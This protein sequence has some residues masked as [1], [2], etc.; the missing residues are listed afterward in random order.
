MRMLTYDPD[1]RISAAEAYKHKW[2]QSKEFCK[3][4]PEKTQELIGNI[5][6]FYVSASD[7]LSRG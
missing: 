3:L 4:D 1:K 7:C 5:N 6:K 2:L